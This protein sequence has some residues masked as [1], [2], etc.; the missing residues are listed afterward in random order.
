MF[1][2][3]DSP[4]R[5]HRVSPLSRANGS[6]S[7][8]LPQIS[9]V[10][11][12]RSRSSQSASPVCPTRGQAAGGRGRRSRRLHQSSDERQSRSRSPESHSPVR[13]TRGRGRGRRGRGRCAVG[14]PAQQ[15][16]TNEGR[17]PS[18]PSFRVDE[19]IDATETADDNGVNAEDVEPGVGDGAAVPQWEIHAGA[20]KRGKDVLVESVGY[21]Y[22]VGKRYDVTHFCKSFT[23]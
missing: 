5:L 21:T 13:A 10:Q 19:T 22:T 6:S 1:C 14:R 2:D 15:Q 7:P 23:A 4:P 8:A 3:R 16:S 9:P 12:I 18:P 17:S 11:S 20:S